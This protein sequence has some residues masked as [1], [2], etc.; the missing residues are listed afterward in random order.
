MTLSDKQQ[1]LVKKIYEDT[2]TEKT[3]N[4][5]IQMVCGKNFDNLV[6]DDIT[7]LIKF[8]KRNES[9]TERQKQMLRNL[10]VYL[11]IDTPTVQTRNELEDI[12][13]ILKKK[14]DIFIPYYINT[15]KIAYTI[16]TKTDDYFI[17][18]Q[19]RLHKLEQKDMKVIIFKEVMMLDYDDISL[20]EIL[21]IITPF[22]YTFWVY[23]TIKGFHVYVMSK[24]F[25]F[26][27]IATLQ[28]M[29]KMG[30]DK[31]YISFTKFYGT[32]VRLEAKPGRTEPYVEKFIRQ[33]NN[34]PVMPEINTLMEIKDAI[35]R[36]N[37]TKIM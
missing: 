16:H 35:I 9:P 37:N 32:V 19:H 36:N 1:K 28:K 29:Y 22:P 27:D 24:L 15:S 18:T 8:S 34:Y 20:D 3:L 6:N 31:W 26:Q 23:Q 17:G 30:C 7:V 33:V 12:S 10:C 13:E 25:N 5:F 14:Y 2:T 11:N 21:R 4:E